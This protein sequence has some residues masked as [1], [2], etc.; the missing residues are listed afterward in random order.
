M[1]RYLLLLILVA[2]TTL[3]VNYAIGKERARYTG[4]R[5]IYNETVI[6]Y[7]RVKVGP[8]PKE[9]LDSLRAVVEK[10][11][12]RFISDTAVDFG[13]RKGP[14]GKWKVAP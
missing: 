9:Q 13:V 8:M 3:G 11:T 14:D 7:I 10:S 2:A 6:A 5:K 4:L 12:P 1:K